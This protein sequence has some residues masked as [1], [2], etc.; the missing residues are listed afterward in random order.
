MSRP[1]TA[2]DRSS[3]IRLASSLVEG[4]Q[5]RKDLLRL[6]KF[7][8]EREKG[9]DEGAAK[10]ASGLQVYTLT[11]PKGPREFTDLKDLIAYQDSLW[12][13]S[14]TPVIR[15]TDASGVS[16]KLALGD[17]F[18]QGFRSHRERL[19]LLEKMIQ[20]KELKV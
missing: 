4:S 6:L 5:E 7:A 10:S 11:T 3:L 1:L 8:G 14:M 2:Q 9:F 15:W 17:F 18:R 16:H 13:V 12:G 19:K 20:E